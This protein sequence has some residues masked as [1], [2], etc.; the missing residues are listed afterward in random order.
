MG[1]IAIAD[2]PLTAPQ[3][4]AAMGLTRQGVQKQLN[5]AR[6]D[7]LIEAVA[8][9]RHERSPRHRLTETGRRAYDA[10]IALQTP[11]TKALAQ[12][13]SLA[14]LKTA[15]D[16]LSTLGARLESTPLP[17]TGE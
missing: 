4:A 10:A 8:N 3:I 11:W 1:A 5:R 13:S 9:P 2:Q 7:G 6:E 12:G 16:L 14:D 15:L 17:F